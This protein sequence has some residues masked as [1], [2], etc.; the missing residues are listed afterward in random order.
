MT[1]LAELG[2]WSA[3]SDVQR[4]GDTTCLIAVLRSGRDVAGGSELAL[5]IADLLEGKIEGK[6]R[7]RLNRADRIARRRQARGWFEYYRDIFRSLEDGTHPDPEGEWEHL[8]QELDQASYLGPIPPE[9]KGPITQA[10]RILTAQV[11]HLTPSQLEDRMRDRS[12][13]ERG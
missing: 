9:G 5:L 2:V 8:R 10:A 6:P 11:L 4:Y 7:R 13:A 1:A 12:R 3:I